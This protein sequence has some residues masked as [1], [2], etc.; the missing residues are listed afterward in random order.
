M[1]TTRVDRLI[2]HI[3]NITKNSSTN[4]AEDISDEEI[5]RF[6]NQAQNRIQ[7]KIVEK[8]PMSFVK[9][10][11][12]SSV[13]S[14]E[15]YNLPED[16]MMDSRIVSVEYSTDGGNDTYYKLRPG[17][18]KHRQTDLKGM[19]KFYIRRNKLDTNTASMILSP[20]PSSS[21]ELLR[22]VY[23]KRIQDLDIRRGVVSDVTDSGTQITSLTLDVSGTPPIDDADLDNHDFICVVDKLGNIKMKNI[24]IDSVNTS[25]GVVTLS[26]S[27]T[28]ESGESITVGDFIVGGKD[29]TTHSR[30]P[31]FIEEY[32]IEYA[33]L[34]IMHRDSNSDLAE[35]FPL[36]SAMERDIVDKFAEPI[37][38][39]IFVEDLI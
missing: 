18:L 33:S 2:T 27:H 23:T 1:S 29:T 11:T 8:D 32:L 20:T 14:Q 5:I 10:T 3:R 30:L 36:L 39:V 17:L 4:S 9:E 31:K 25:T 24:Q 28:Y 26:Q 35:Q 7:S 37:D 15:E 16:L 38:D 34:K 6:L 13:N 19:P 22:V 21:S 12:I